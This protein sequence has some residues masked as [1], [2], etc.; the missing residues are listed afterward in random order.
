M[1]KD[2]VNMKIR[3]DQEKIEYLIIFAYFF[4][5][6]VAKISNSFTSK[7]VVYS[8]WLGIVFLYLFLKKLTITIDLVV[9]YVGF[10]IIYLTGIVMNSQYVSMQHIYAIVIYL[11][12]AYYV[13]RTAGRN[14]QALRKMLYISAYC[15]LMIY[16]PLCSNAPATSYMDYAYGILINTCIVIFKYIEENKYRDIIISCIGTICAIV[17]C[18]RGAVVVLIAMIIYY[19][20]SS[21][22]NKKYRFPGVVLV[23]SILAW[24]YIDKILAYINMRGIQSR[25]ISKLLSL[26]FFE[27]VGRNALG[28]K[29]VYLISKNQW[30]YGPFSNRSLL[31]PEP[32]PHNWIYELLIDYG[33]YLGV[34]LILQIILLGIYLVINN[35]NM[36]AKIAIIFYIIGIS[37]QLISNSLYYTN[38]FTVALAL[39]INV[40]SKHKCQKVM[41]YE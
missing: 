16:I 31:Y 33:W 4:V 27:S 24:K 1:E 36:T 3:I 10:V 26:S 21:I 15:N 28:E 6:A 38:Y 7:A 35:K 8:I 37:I 32:Y 22:L 41:R 23:L 34:F 9:Y 19:F 30:G 11:F 40:Y 18:S 13:M 29:C 14:E 12:P 2:I 17:Y 39:G 5:G 25:N 20:C